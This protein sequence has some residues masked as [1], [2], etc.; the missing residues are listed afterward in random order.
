MLQILIAPACFLVAGL[1]GHLLGTPARVAGGLAALGSAHLL[2]FLGAGQ[3]LASDGAMAGWVHVASQL[4]FVG[5]FV[6]LVWLAAAYPDEKPSPKV[7]T[8]AALLA[9]T[10]PVLA[11][12]SGPTPSIIDAD[13]ELGPVVQL[14]PEGVA[15]LGGLALVLLPV[16]ALVLF[17]VRYRRAGADDRAAMRWPIA[18]LGVV[19]G[20]VLLGVVAGSRYDNAVTWMWLLAAPVLPLTLALG[21]VLRRLDSMTGELAHLRDA[22]RR[23]PRPEA[24]PEA[25]ARLTPRELTVLRAMA[26]GLS[27]PEIA[28]SMHLSLSSVEKHATSIFRKFGLTDATQGHRRVSAVVTYRDA[29]ESARDERQDEVRP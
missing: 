23:P 19:A 1:I 4:L 5:G 2:A 24:T 14:L 26:E 3:A 8:A 18:G 12:M 21:P 11:A 28:K 29:V 16:L 10:G 9:V 27:N 20:L 7:V 25:L 17:V 15:N 13:R 6:A 22:A